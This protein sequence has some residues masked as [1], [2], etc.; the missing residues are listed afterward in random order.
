MLP[1]Y[2]ANND[3]KLLVIV[4]ISASFFLVGCSSA[5]KTSTTNLSGDLTVGDKGL[6]RLPGITDKTQVICLAPN[7]KIYR[8][9]TKALLARDSL[10]ILRLGDEGVFC[11]GNGSKIKVLET[12]VGL[13]RVRILRG[14]NPVDVDKVGME[15]WTSSEFVVKE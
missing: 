15:G 12:S 8:E 1:I 3:M 7:S 10:G 5:D 13:K 14:S 11:V 4:I 6:L 2:K 9:L